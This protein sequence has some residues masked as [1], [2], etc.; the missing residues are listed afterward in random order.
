MLKSLAICF[1]LLMKMGHPKR[2]CYLLSSGAI[3]CASTIL[4]T[5]KPVEALHDP[6]LRTLGIIAEGL[7][8]LPLALSLTFFAACSFNTAKLQSDAAKLYKAQPN[9]DSKNSELVDA[10]SVEND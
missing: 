7:V 4:M 5:Y 2:D 9:E 10:E 1:Q 6:Y 8:L 3:A